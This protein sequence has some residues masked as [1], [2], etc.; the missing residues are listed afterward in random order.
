MQEL[1]DLIFSNFII[2]AA[3]IGGILSWIGGQS[4]KE[5]EANK[6]RRSTGPFMPEQQRER[7]TESSSFPEQTQK[8][9]EERLKDYYESKQ[10]KLKE[11]KEDLSRGSKPLEPISDFS[12]ETPNQDI[13]TVMQEKEAR[14]GK[15]S[16]KISDYDKV[17][18]L[19]RPEKW[20]RKRLAEGIV[21]SEILGRPRAYKPHTS[22]PRKR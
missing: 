21:M 11:V 8:T 16:R 1:L 6:P 13:H 5:D 4:R 15:E 3:I 2:I 9:G 7:P 10:E 19:S 18:N 22:N 20:D 17:S 14:P 12:Y